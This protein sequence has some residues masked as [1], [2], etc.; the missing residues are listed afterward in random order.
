VRIQARQIPADGVRDEEVFQVAEKDIKP[1]AP[2]KARSTEKAAAGV[3][4]TS[5]KKRRTF[6]RRR[7]LKRRGG[8]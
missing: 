4:K 1:E 8:K 3:S 7:S 6:K 2:A 5:L